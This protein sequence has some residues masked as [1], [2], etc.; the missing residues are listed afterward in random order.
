M[1]EIETQAIQ[2]QQQIGIVRSQIAI[3]QREIRKHELTAEEMAKLPSDTKMYEGVGKMYVSTPLSPL[4]FHLVF[5]A[6]NIGHKYAMCVPNI[7]I[8]RFDQAK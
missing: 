2:S 8:T 4:G 5:T 6:S 1:T 7:M 3:K